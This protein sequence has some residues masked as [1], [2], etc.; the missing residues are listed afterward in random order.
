[1]VGVKVIANDAEFQSEL[2]AAGS[3]LVVAKFTMRG[4]TQVDVYCFVSLMIVFVKLEES[5]GIRVIRPIYIQ[6]L[7]ARKR[8][9]L[10]MV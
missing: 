8:D 2:C 10:G 5:E 7:L 4:G 6:C 1:M 3:R 9:Y